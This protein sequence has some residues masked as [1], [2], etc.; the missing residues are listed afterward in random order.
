MPSPLIITRVIAPD[1]LPAAVVPTGYDYDMWIN[2]GQSNA[3]GTTE[4]PWLTQPPTLTAGT[5]YEW[6]GTTFVEKSGTPDRASG[7][8]YLGVYS[9][10]GNGRGGYQSEFARRINLAT[11]RKQLWVQ[12]APGGSYIVPGRDTVGGGNWTDT[13][14]ANARTQINAAIAAANAA[15]WTFRIRGFLWTQ[16]EAEGG[17]LPQEVYTPSAYQTALNNIVNNL[18]SNY[19]SLFDPMIGGEGGFFNIIANIGGG[20]TNGTERWPGRNTNRNYDIWEIHRNTLPAANPLVKAICLRGAWLAARSLLQADNIHVTRAGYDDLGQ[21]AALNMIDGSGKSIQAAPTGLTEV[22][23]TRAN[24]RVSWTNN[25]VT[26]RRIVIERKETS[27]SNWETI[28]GLPTTAT[29]M[30]VGIP[31]RGV[32][33][34]IRVGVWGDDGIWYSNTLTVTIAANSVPADYFAVS[35]VSGAQATNIT[36]CISDLSAAG[37]L[38]HL[39]QFTIFRSGYNAD[40][41]TTAFDVM[42]NAD[43]TLSASGVTR[44]AD[45]YQLDGVAGDIWV[46]YNNSPWPCQGSGHTLLMWHKNAGSGTQVLWRMGKDASGDVGLNTLVGHNTAISFRLQVLNGTY[47]FLSQI[48]DGFESSGANFTSTAIADGTVRDVC[49]RYEPVTGKYEIYAAGSATRVT[50]SVAARFMQMYSGE[51]GPRLGR[52]N[53]TFYQSAP[54]IYMLFSRPLT[55]AEYQSVR[56]IVNSRIV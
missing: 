49:M 33:Y 15:G 6:N 43:W 2:L 5:F 8:G 19:S 1:K 50:R 12:Y 41:G 55:V 25:A 42:R 16:G 56:T 13:H 31:R 53:N 47:D 44:N 30:F 40:T 18:H 52:L 9:G 4:N 10:I 22:A 36:N 3:Q 21:T 27:A 11:G 14:L 7:A 26:P 34:D 28:C 35:G 23:R 48:Q 29:T 37:V 17:D 24:V 54:S 51:F 46:P 32:S 38:D 39:A 45:C 20:A